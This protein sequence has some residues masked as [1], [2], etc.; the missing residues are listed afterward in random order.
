MT[1]FNRL[2]G[3]LEQSLTDIDDAI[4]G[5]IV[6]DETLDKMYLSI[7]NNQVPGNWSEVSYLSLKPLS[8]WFK[9]M[10]VRVQTIDNWLR[11]GNPSS[12]WLSG[13]FFPQG[14]MTGVLQTHARKHTVAIDKLQ[15][16]FEILEAETFEEIE[17]QPEDGV[18]IHGLYS[19]GA[20]WDRE[21]QI[22]NEQEPQVL[23]DTMPVIWF[24]PFEDYVP[25]A[26]EYQA[27]L[28]KAANREG[29]LNTTGQSTN[30]ILHVSIPT[31]MAPA[32]WT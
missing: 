12:F 26:E 17:E 32:H 11:N 3:V 4:N 15:W 30:F 22:L 27:P 9:D 7:Q 5:R 2:L 31:T 14:F 19:D 28:Y 8:S 10:L 13:M 21:N 29:K 18:Y 25:P 20:R 24:K 6:M 16:Q 23:F 1:K